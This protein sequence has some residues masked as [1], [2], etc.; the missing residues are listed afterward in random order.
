MNLLSV[1]MRM[2]T[3]RDSALAPSQPHWLVTFRGRWCCHII[4]VMGTVSISSGCKEVTVGVGMVS[5]YWFVL[6][7]VGGA[8]L[9]RE[10]RVLRRLRGN[11]QST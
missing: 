10:Y 1:T 5:C 8:A 2:I 7:T 3:I 9:W 6:F 4:A 11:L